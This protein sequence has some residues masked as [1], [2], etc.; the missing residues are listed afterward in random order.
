MCIFRKDHV[1]V[2]TGLEGHW[3]S[4]SHSQTVAPP[5]LN[6]VALGKL[7]GEVSGSS[8]AAPQPVG[9]GARGVELR[10]SQLPPLLRRPSRPPVPQA[11]LKAPWSRGP[12]RQGL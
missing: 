7:A 8:P 9:R 11:A 2:S 12:G 1:E 6:F 4:G 10:G 5:P 3:A